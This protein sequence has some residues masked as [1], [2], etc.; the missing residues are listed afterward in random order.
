MSATADRGSMSASL[1]LASSG[2]QVERIPEEGRV[3]VKKTEPILE[4]C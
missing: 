2:S 3:D 1:A 4:E